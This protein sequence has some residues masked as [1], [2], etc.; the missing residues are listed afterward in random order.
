MQ[1]MQM[2]AQT[3]ILSS[4]IIWQTRQKIDFSKVILT[5][6]NL[7]VT[8]GSGRRQSDD[9]KGWRQLSDD[10]VWVT[11]WMEVWV[12]LWVHNVECQET[13]SLPVFAPCLRD[14][15]LVCLS[16]CKVLLCKELHTVRIQG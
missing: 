7:E 8:M 11:V 15:L 6:T 2:A 4:S 9:H 5:Q 10:V 16:V 13:E 1:C 14:C 12:H 3:Q